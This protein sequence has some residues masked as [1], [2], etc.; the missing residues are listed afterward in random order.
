MPRGIP[1]S[2]H[3]EKGAGRKPLG[4]SPM[5]RRNVWLSDEQVAALREIGGG[6]LSAGIRVLLSHATTTAPAAPVPRSHR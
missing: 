6:N 5:Q 4:P 3:R 1:K 2:G